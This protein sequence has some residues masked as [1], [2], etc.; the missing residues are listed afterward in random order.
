MRRNLLLGILL[1]SLLISVPVQGIQVDAV[2]TDRYIVNTDPGYV[3]Y[4]IIIND[5][6]VGTNQTHLLYQSG[7]TFLLEIHSAQ[8]YGLH[9]EFWINLSYPNG[10]TVSQYRDTWRISR[11]VYKT[12][13]QPVFAQ[14]ESLTFVAWTIDLQ[15]GLSPLAAEFN[16]APASWDPASAIPFSMAQGT[17]GTA[18]DIHVYEMATSEF[19]SNV[20]NY[21]PSYGLSNLAGQVF[22]WSYTAVIGFL[23]QIPVIGPEMVS[24]VDFIGSLGGWF[25][26]WITFL[27]DHIWELVIGIEALIAMFAVINNK[28]GSLEDFISLMVEYNL[29]TISGGIRVVEMAYNLIGQAIDVIA[30]IIQALKPV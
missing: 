11:G 24:I 5:I 14:M 15:V 17:I 27:K 30:K 21:N 25:V 8:S 23:N 10:T 6:P 22:Q 19:N 26:F 29:K 9:N 16:T 20:V 1:I 7:G 12:T 4:Q 18:T 3:I 2:N 13:I 28:K